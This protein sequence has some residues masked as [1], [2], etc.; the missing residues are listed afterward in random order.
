MSDIIQQAEVIGKQLTELKQIT[1][2]VIEL[3]Q[4][5]EGKASR[6]LSYLQLDHHTLNRAVDSAEKDEDEAYTKLTYE[7]NKGTRNTK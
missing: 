6:T 5:R 4:I 3:R 2:A 1:K 7:V